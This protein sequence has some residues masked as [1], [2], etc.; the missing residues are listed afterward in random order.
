MKNPIPILR[1]FLTNHVAPFDYNYKE[2]A[3]DNYDYARR[4]YDTDF[5]EIE[6]IEPE[7][8][9]L[10]Q[11]LEITIEFSTLHDVCAG[12]YD[13]EPSHDIELENV[14]ATKIVFWIAEERYNLTEDRNAKK[15]IKNFIHN[16]Q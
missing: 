12:G 7:K 5:I 4:Q 16:E 6:A 3:R 2:T 11:L 15:L 10:E 1:D 8:L 13:E 14:E 9:T